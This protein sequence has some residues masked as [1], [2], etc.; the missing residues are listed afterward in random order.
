[1][2][3]AFTPGRLALLGHQQQGRRRGVKHHRRAC[4]EA[5]VAHVARRAFATKSCCETKEKSKHGT[6][7]ED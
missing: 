3:A 1:M 6:K 4:A 7:H 5:E 2:P